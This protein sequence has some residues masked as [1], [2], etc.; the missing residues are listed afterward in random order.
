MEYKKAS[1]HFNR[2]NAEGFDEHVARSIPWY[3]EGHGLILKFSEF[4]IRSGDPI[5]DLGCSTGALAY[6]LAHLHAD[7][8]AQVIAIDESE[9][10]IAL[11]STKK[12]PNLKFVRD[13]ILTH[14]FQRSNFFVAYYTLH[15]LSEGQRSEMMKKIH[16]ALNPGGAFILYEKTRSESAT[17]ESMMSTLLTEFKLERGETPEQVIQKTLSLKGILNPVSSTE[18]LNALKGTGFRNVDRIFKMNSFEGF[19]AIK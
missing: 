8:K 3:E 1:W 19:L 12:L 7:K 15:F 16:A 4:F 10:M 11:A 17:I 13:N 9:D 14:S 18:V 6:D 5:Y 2:A